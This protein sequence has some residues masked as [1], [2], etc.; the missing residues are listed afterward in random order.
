MVAVP[1]IQ[2]EVAEEPTDYILDFNLN[3]IYISNPRYIWRLTY[4]ILNKTF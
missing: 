3:E 2:K 1:E 4:N